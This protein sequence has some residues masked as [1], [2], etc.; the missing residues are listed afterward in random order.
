MNH[1]FKVVDLIENMTFK[2]VES[3]D[4]IKVNDYIIQY[5]GD[6]LEW[7]NT[8]W[9]QLDYKNT[10]LNYYGVTFVIDKENILKMKEILT[11][12]ISLFNNAPLEFTISAD[13]NTDE[14]MFE[15][16][17]MK[18]SEVIS[19]IKDVITLCDQALKEGK[20]LVH[21]GI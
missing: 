4:G 1:K 19:E 2:D 8:S 11:S 6:S 15:K 3:A 16:I 14:L 13:Y 7:L 18:K 17:E 5:I 21:F 10:G 9:N 20:I 12:W